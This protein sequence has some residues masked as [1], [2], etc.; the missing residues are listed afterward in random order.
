MNLADKAFQSAEKQFIFMLSD[1]QKSMWLQW[2]AELDLGRRSDFL[3][4][5][6]SCG[7]CL[8]HFQVEWTAE[9]VPMTKSWTLSDWGRCFLLQRYLPN[10]PSSQRLEL[11]ED[12]YRRGDIYEQQAVLQ[13]LDFL[14]HPEAFKEL[15]VNALRT[16]ATS[17]FAALALGNSYPQKHFSTDEFNQMVLKAMFI[18]LPLDLVVELSSKLNPELWQMIG[19]YLSERKIAQRSLPKSWPWLRTLGEELHY[20][21]F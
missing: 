16:N 4:A 18:D 1:A 12:L 9:L 7:R 11:V 14:P 15:A 5:F 8:G 6:S 3:A 20:E 2:Q 10:L 21:V 19:D 17:V 13:A